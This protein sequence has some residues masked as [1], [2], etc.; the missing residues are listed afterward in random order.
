MVY[1]GAT[2]AIAREKAPMWLMQPR[3]DAPPFV[4]TS[5]AT[6]RAPR[7]GWS[8]GVTRWGASVE[9]MNGNEQSRR[10]EGWDN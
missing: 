3:A 10:I 6:S 9:L 5:G 1:P 4:V 2:G 8:A 7:R